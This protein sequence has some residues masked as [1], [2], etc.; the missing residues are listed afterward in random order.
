MFS[1]IMDMLF[2]LADSYRKSKKKAELSVVRNIINEADRIY[3]D[4]QRDRIEVDSREIIPENDIERLALTIPGIHV[5]DHAGKRFYE[6]SIRCSQRVY[7]T[8]YEAVRKTLQEFGEI[9]AKYR[10]RCKDELHADMIEYLMMAIEQI[11]ADEDVAKE[12]VIE[13]IDQYLGKMDVR[14]VGTYIA[15]PIEIKD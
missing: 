5:Y 11:A 13:A 14:K 3:R 7:D 8:A 4:A 15:Y 9:D 6:V 10:R 1:D 2:R 12:Q